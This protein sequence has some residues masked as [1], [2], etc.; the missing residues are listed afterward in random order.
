MV[1]VREVE[2]DDKTYIE[3]GDRLYDRKVNPVGVREKFWAVRRGK[4]PLIQ[5]PPK[6]TDL[7]F[8]FNRS[9]ITNED[10]GEVIASKFQRLCGLKSVEYITCKFTDIDGVDHYGV[11][12]GSFKKD[13][14]EI[15][16]SGYRLQTQYTDFDFD[17]KTGKPGK[18]INTVYSFLRDLD[19]LLEDH[20]YKD[21]FLEDI[22]IGLLMQALIDFLLAQTD[23]HWLNTEFI[24]NFNNNSYSVRKAHTYDSGCIAFLKRKREAIKTFA[25]MIKKDYLNAPIMHTLMDKYCPMFGIKTCLVKIDTKKAE[26][27]C[28]VEK[29]DV[30]NSKANQKAFLSELT[31]E[32]LNNPD[33]A[34]FYIKLKENFKYDKKTKLLDLSML[35]EVLKR[36]GE[37]IPDEIREMVTAVVNYQ[38]NEIERELS[39]KINNINCVEENTS[40]EA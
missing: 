24:E 18:A 40:L 8:K 32:I 12:C 39:K 38:L 10:Y 22:K 11:M 19:L 25:S 23:R 36:N 14:S 37:E 15:G 2:F 5:E 9:A 1:E 29:I 21:L 28:E 20:P 33:L 6:V 7:L 35:F 3:V 27:Y 34:Y 17:K 16:T 13:N 31:D 30:D 4:N 26:K